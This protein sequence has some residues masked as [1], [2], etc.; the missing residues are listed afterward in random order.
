MSKTEKTESAESPINA[1]DEAKQNELVNFVANNILNSITLNQTITVIQQ[2]A[3]REATKIVTEADEEKLAQIE[4]AF[5]AA[6]NPPAEAEESA[7]A[8]EKVAEKT[9][10]KSASKAKETA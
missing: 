9:K 1:L 2:V 6:Q 7:P 4:S 5:E 10:K 8:E 3:L